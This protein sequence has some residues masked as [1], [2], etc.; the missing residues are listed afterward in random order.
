MVLGGVLR[1][2]ADYS[3]VETFGFWQVL[4][5]LAMQGS[6]GAMSGTQ[7]AL[8]GNFINVTHLR[9]AT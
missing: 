9:V 6:S 7:C 5:Q 8:D 3:V 2:S 1:C 4:S